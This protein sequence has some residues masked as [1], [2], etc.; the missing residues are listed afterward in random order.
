MDAQ[1]QPSPQFM[2]VVPSDGS[3]LPAASRAI[4]IGGAGDLRV[5]SIAGDTVTFVGVPAGSVLPIRCS[6]VLSTGTTATNLV[7]LC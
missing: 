4:Y 2:A 6:R 3:D 5:M 1:L 7:A